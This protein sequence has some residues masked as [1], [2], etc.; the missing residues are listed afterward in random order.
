MATV[1]D[2]LDLARQQIGTK[3]NPA[4]SNKVKYNTWYYGREVSGPSY[5]WCMAFI[6]WLFSQLN[7][8][9]LLPVKTASCSALMNAAR[10]T[11]EWT[12]GPY[13]PGDI[14]IYDFQGDGIVDHVGIVEIVSGN[15]VTAIEGNTS[16]DSVGSQSNGGMVCRKTRALKLIKGAVRPKYE[17]E[18]DMDISKL[19]DS[20]VLQLADRMQ[21]L[22]GRKTLTGALASEFAEAKAAGITDGSNPYAFCTKAQ[23]AVMT[24]RSSKKN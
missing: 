1:K 14:V 4:N 15:T 6:M 9:N 22:L 3:E 7:A 12:I 21:T 24:L 11:G 20:E 10:I 8:L 19:T 23:A 16:P 18:D 17:K 13:K 5:P 2:I